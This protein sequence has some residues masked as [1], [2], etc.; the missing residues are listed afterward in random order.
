VQSFQWFRAGAGV[1]VVDQHQ[2]VLSLERYDVRGAWQLPQGGLEPNETPVEAAQRE[3]FEE[4]GL[5]WDQLQLLGEHP[6]WLA[7]ELP[8]EAQTPKTGRGQVQRWFVLRLRDLNA[9][10]DLGQP[11]PGTARP[12]FA[13]YRWTSFSELL[14]GA[15]AFRRPVYEQLAEFVGTLDASL[16]D[17]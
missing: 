12:E 5:V 17:A 16:G 2:L 15:V 14:E 6:R 9:R 4:T 10:L 8:P 1:V 7:Y 3:I 11:S 13:A